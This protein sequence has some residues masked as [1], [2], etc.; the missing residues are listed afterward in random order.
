MDQ[1]VE[2]AES[3]YCAAIHC[4]AFYFG[5]LRTNLPNCVTKTTVLGHQKGPWNYRL[6]P[7]VDCSEIRL[8][9]KER[10]GGAVVQDTSAHPHRRSICRSLPSTP[11]VAG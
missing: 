2:I 6:Q 10:S 1:P 4:F 5:S 7:G 11:I 8:K 3:A 9:T